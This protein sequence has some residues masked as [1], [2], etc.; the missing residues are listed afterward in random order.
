MVFQYN[1]INN[2]NWN[3]FL[4]FPLMYSQ[5][6]R[7]Y[8]PGLFFTLLAGYFLG[9]FLNQKTVHKKQIVGFAIAASLAAYSHYFSLL[10]T[11]LL[12]IAGIFLLLKKFDGAT[13]LHVE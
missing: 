3:F 6:A 1:R 7:P 11:T 12:A 10:V 13:Y 8:A 9:Q 4:Q 5:L 2:S